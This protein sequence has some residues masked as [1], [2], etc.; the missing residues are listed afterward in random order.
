[1]SGPMHSPK[2]CQRNHGNARS[3][4]AALLLP[5]ATSNLKLLPINQE[6][7][8]DTGCPNPVIEGLSTRKLN[9]GQR[10]SLV[11]HCASSN[12]EEEAV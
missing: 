6:A 12:L 5:I 3:K 4:D 2:N 9:Y 11:P 8:P 10:S 1:M 7:D